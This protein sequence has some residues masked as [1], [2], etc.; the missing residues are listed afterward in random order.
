MA[1]YCSNSIVFY[2]KRKKPLEEI[3]QLVS[4]CLGNVKLNSVKQFLIFADLKRLADGEFCDGRDYFVNCDAEVEKDLGLY[5]LR[6]ETETAWSPNMIVIEL[7]LKAKYNGTVKMVYE[8][9]EV[10][11]NVYVN[12]DKLGLYFID[13]YKVEF[14]YRDNTE[15]EYFTDWRNT[16]KYLHE[17]FP[18][19]KLCLTEDLETAEKKISKA[20]KFSRVD[21]EYI[22]INEFQACEDDRKMWR[23]I[24]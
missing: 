7:M 2:S 10:G 22:N 5:C 20:Y 9:E 15:S 18:L 4:R 13:R 19:A 17:K 16:I 8:S 21:C 3:R 6:V 14:N 1:N 12:T 24:A 11:S 23:V